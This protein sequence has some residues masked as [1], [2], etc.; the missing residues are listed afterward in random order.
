MKNVSRETFWI[1]S[2]SSASGKTFG[3]LNIL[4]RSKKA[5]TK[6]SAMKKSFLASNRI[7][8]AKRYGKRDFILYNLFNYS[9][10]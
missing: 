5:N 3:G 7:K 2:Y 8:R 10:L 1:Q 4:D 6:Y 9:G